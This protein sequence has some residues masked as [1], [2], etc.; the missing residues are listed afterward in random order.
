MGLNQRDEH[1]AFAFREAGMAVE[2]GMK[3]MARYGRRYRAHDTNQFELATQNGDDQSSA[4]LCI[5]L[6]QIL[7]KRTAN[8]T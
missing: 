1:V 6:Q 3:M 4:C 7:Q 5:P 8:F 2:E